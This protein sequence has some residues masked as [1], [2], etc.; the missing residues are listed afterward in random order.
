MTVS[1]RPATIEDMDSVL[2]LIKELAAYENSP[3]EVIVTAEQLK[4]DGFGEQ[5]VFDCFVAE[6]T[7]RKLIGMALYYTGYSTWKGKTL[8]LEDFLVNETY[9]KNGVG[10]KLFDTVVEEAKNRKVKRMDWQVLNWNEPAINFYKKNNSILDEE[11]TNGR[12]FFNI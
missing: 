6:T 7:E 5:K 4:L 11:W 10:Q 8:Y 9:R 12:L 3:N 2:L 1:I